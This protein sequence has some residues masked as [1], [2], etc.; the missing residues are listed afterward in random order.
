MSPVPNPL[1]AT[2]QDF[3]PPGRAPLDFHRR[4]PEYAVTL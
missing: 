2:E 3:A 1:A 4:L